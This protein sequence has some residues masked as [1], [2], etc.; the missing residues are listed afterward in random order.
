LKGAIGDIRGLAKKWQTPNNLQVAVKHTCI[1][2]CKAKKYWV[3]TILSPQYLE[4]YWGDCPHAPICSRRLWIWQ[5]HAVFEL[6]KPV[7]DSQRNGFMFRLANRMA[8]ITWRGLVWCHYCV[9][10]NFMLFCSFLKWCM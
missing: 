7:S 5:L 4:K 10:K 8:R 1:K 3:E 9:L 2:R 6:S